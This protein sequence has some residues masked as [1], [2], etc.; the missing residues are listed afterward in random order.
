MDRVLTDELRWALEQFISIA[1]GVA[2]VALILLIATV[3]A[4]LLRGRLRHRLARTLA[5]ENAKR[6]VENL[7]AVGIFGV[8]L[9]LILTLMGVTWTTLLTAVGLSTLVVA[10]GLQG[11]LQSLVAGG[12][13]LFERPYN[14]GDHIKFSVHDIEGTV[15]EIAFRTTVIRTDDGT[16]V[17]T[18]NSFIFTQAVANYSPERAILTIVTAHGTGGFAGTDADM[19]SIV[20]AALADVPGLTTTPDVMVTS[21]F[22]DKGLSKRIA[23]EPRVGLW[24]AHLMRG[25]ADQTTQVR[26]SWRGRTDQTVREEVV[27]RLRVLFPQARIGVRRW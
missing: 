22:A 2:Q 26:V 27:R 8:A 15:E 25:L 19:R 13:I 18:P 5:P 17:V 11:V 7:V 21:R 20:K 9:T 1:I 6:M 4:R 24:A 23:R 12:F 16:R 14:V 10:L 3:F